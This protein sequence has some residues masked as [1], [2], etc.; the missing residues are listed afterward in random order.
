[1]QDFSKFLSTISSPSELTEVMAYLREH[2]P[3]T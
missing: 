1:M 3:A 2:V